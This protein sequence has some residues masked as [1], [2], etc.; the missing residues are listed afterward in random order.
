V[1]NSLV[2]NC[3]L[4]S[5][6]ALDAMGVIFEAG[7]DVEK[8]LIPFA[9]RRGCF[10]G[11]GEISAAYTRCSLGEYNSAALWALLGLSGDAEQ[12]DRAYIAQHR[13]TTG[14][15]IF[16]DTARAK[17][18]TVGCLTNDVTEWS[19][20]L[21]R[22]HCL[23]KSMSPWIVSGELG[24]RKPEPQIYLRFV[25]AACCRPDECLFV[26]DRPAN[27]S[28][29]LELGF[30]VVQFK[31]DATALT[32]NAYPQVCSFRSLSIWLKTCLS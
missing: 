8:L 29:A 15:D 1:Q 6:I 5:A 7:D 24:V 18:I 27:L 17:G 11:D 28:T 22:T 16:L 32:D 10:L 20:L 4:P 31:S 26:D 9:R 13:L 12:L 3:W 2:S 30:R 21:R 19:R 23:D 25:E 14:L